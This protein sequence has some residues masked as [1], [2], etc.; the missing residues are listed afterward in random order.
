MTRVGSADEEGKELGSPLVSIIVNT[1]TA[2]PFITAT[3]FMWIAH[4]QPD[5]VFVLV[6]LMLG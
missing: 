5:S 1:T 2:A 3:L 6:S 4:V